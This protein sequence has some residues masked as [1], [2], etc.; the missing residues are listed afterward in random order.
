M[1]KHFAGLLCTLLIL[2]ITIISWKPVGFIK[3]NENITR[4]FTAKELLEKYIGNVYE[5]AHL[6]ESGMDAD[7]FKKGLTGFLNLKIADKLSQNTSI[8]TIVDFNKSSREKRM[9]IID[10]INKELILNTWVAHGQGSGDDMAT[11]FS[12][13]MDTHKSSLGFYLT[14]DVYLGK[15]GRSLRLNGLDEGFNTNARARDIVVHAADY[16]GKNTIDQ[17]GRLGRSFGCPAVSPEV[18]DEVIN[19]IKDKTVLFINGNV[20]NYSSKYLDED[21]AANFLSAQNGTYVANL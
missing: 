2:S 18:A 1:R 8:L 20:S 19:T 13:K 7:V 11:S 9:W 10:V 4:S 17:L 5:A 6:Q 21:L 16:V 14:D 12:D 15:H 3:S